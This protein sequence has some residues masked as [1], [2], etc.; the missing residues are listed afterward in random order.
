MVTRS[1]IEVDLLLGV[2][3]SSSECPA[4]GKRVFVTGRAGWSLDKAHK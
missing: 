4:R 3:H 1:E 2:F